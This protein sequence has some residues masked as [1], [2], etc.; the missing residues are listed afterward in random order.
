M[1]AMA[2]PEGLLA[3]AKNYLDITWA[4]PAADSKLT[5]QIQ[6]GMSYICEK[7]GV[8]ASAFYGE[9]TDGRAQELLFNYLLYDRAGS[10]DQFKANYRS[11]IVGLKIRQEVRDAARAKG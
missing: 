9:E 3:A 2:V 4:D 1:A 5:G 8:S 6:R 11:D 7:T 10:V